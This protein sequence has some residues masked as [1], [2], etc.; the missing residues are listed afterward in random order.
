MLRWLGAYVLAGAV[1][2]V[3][4]NAF[5]Q[6]PNEFR[7]TEPGSL[8][9]GVLQV[10]IGTSMMAAAWGLVRRARWASR[11]IGLGGGAAVLL[12]LAQPMFEPMPWDAARSILLGAAVVAVAAAGMSWCARRL[13]SPS[14]AAPASGVAASD[15]G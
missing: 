4:G 2:L 1:L 14:A 3:G 7:A 9:F 15:A 5:R 13:A 11:A 6:V 12:L 8:L 10:L